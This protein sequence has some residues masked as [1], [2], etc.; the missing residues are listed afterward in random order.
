MANPILGS[1]H[2]AFDNPS[3]YGVEVHAWLVFQCRL[4][5]QIERE[6]DRVFHVLNTESQVLDMANIEPD[7]EARTMS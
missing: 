3:V 2:I 1:R 4:F 5:A 7:D 6:N